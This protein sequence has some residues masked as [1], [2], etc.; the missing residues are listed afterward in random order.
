[1]KVLQLQTEIPCR[2]SR[3][4]FLIRPGSR[5]LRPS[6]PGSL[7][8][9]Y[10]LVHDNSS[11]RGFRDNQRPRHMRPWQLHRCDFLLANNRSS[12]RFWQHTIGSQPRLSDPF[13]SLLSS[14]CYL[15]R[16]V[17]PANC[18]HWIFRFLPLL[19]QTIT[20]P[21]GL[22]ICSFI[23][24]SARRDLPTYIKSPL[25]P[26]LVDLLLFFRLARSADRPSSLP[27]GTLCR[28]CP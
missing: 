25:F 4:A 3:E 11:S 16:L 1:M 22:K 28:H 26:L 7:G 2:L 20:R 6:R 12:R 15:I 13:S 8:Q 24:P 18:L 10:P 23:Y 5:H 27:S 17:A 9:Q 14:G 19:P 21:A